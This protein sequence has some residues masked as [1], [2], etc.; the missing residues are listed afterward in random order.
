MIELCVTRIVCQA[1]SAMTNVL[2][3]LA[4]LVFPINSN[5]PPPACITMNDEQCPKI[6]VMASFV[7]NGH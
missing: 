2:S 1:H 7:A 6:T 5:F 3:A 4:R